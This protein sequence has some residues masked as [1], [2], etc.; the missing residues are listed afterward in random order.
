MQENIYKLFV[1]HLFCLWSWI[2]INSILLCE[3]FIDQEEK[4]ELQNNPMATQFWKG[5][6]LLVAWG[7]QLAA[8]NSFF[9]TLEFNKD[10]SML[11]LSQAGIDALFYDAF[12]E[13]EPGSEKPPATWSLGKEERQGSWWRFCVLM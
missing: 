10:L 7:E 1:R 4:F 6:A 8:A 5:I 9:S 2:S 13:I 12:F 11:P 3:T